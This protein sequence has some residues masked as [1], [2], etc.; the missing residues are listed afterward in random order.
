MSETVTG[1]RR[2]GRSQLRLPRRWRRARRWLLA[3][4]VALSVSWLGLAAMVL[5]LAITARTSIGSDQ[6]RSAYW[7]I[8]L[9]VI[10]VEGPVSVCA[11]VTGVLCSLASPWGLFRYWWVVVSL[12]ITC[13]TTLLTLFVLPG[14]ARLAWEAAAAHNLVSERGAGTSLVAAGSVSTTLYAF[15][16]F[17]NVLK[18]WG[19]VWL[20]RHN[21]TRIG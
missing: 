19:R 2:Q 13:L 3:A 4:H 7:T 12:V 17:I 1:Q 10:M 21:Q 18:P 9:A 14:T 15:L 5:I 11:L 20:P 16:T 6:A 8:H